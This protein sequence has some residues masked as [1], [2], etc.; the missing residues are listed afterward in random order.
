MDAIIT[1]VSMIKKESEQ[2]R[3]LSK[4]KKKEALIT[5]SIITAIIVGALYW[6]GKTSDQE[7]SI[8][9][10]ALNNGSIYSKG[11]I[12]SIFYYKGQS[13]RVK[14]IVKGKEYEYRGGWDQNPRHLAKNDSIRIRY[15]TS[16]PS[17]SITELE[18]EF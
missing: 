3:P 4:Q 7:N 1:F 6:L 2:K 8:R 17:F 13:I 12:T 11:I 5:L 9:L 15:A 14:Y 16:D 10:K 18:D